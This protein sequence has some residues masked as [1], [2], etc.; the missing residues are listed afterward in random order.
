MWKIKYRVLK[1]YIFNTLVTFV[2]LYGVEVWG[3]NL[4]K[5]TRKEKNNFKSSFLRSQETN[6]IYP[7]TS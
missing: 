1:K 3:G 2:L 6:I 7:H 4:P 5:S